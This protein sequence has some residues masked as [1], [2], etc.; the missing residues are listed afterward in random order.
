[1][2][3]NPFMPFYVGDWRSDPEV[4][5]L[6]PAERGV[7]RELIDL[8]WVEKPPGTIPL[9][10]KNVVHL[11][12][13]MG[14]FTRQFNVAWEKVVKF[15]PEDPNNP[16]RRHN[17][18]IVRVLEDLERRRLRGVAGGKAR[19]AQRDGQLDAKRPVQ[20]NAPRDPDLDLEV[21]KKNPP[22]PQGVYSPEFEAFWKAYRTACFHDAPGSKENASKKWVSL[23]PDVD[24]R[25]KIMAG[26]ER[27]KSARAV[28]RGKGDFF[29]Q[30]PHAERFL[31]NRRFEDE[32]KASPIPDSPEY[33]EAVERYRQDKETLGGIDA[34][35]AL[36]A[37]HP[38]IATAVLKEV[39]LGR[40]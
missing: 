11:I 29:Q 32:F 22:T 1:M 34:V 6:S 15:W 38:D 37:N 35:E 24:L 26:V 40:T 19:Q 13:G 4:M 5:R 18:K 21:I 8:S 31:G 3:K 7:Y 27:W 30:F 20:R 28:A 36:K 9:L 33:R 17:P 25:K 12:P 14:R 39:N 2:P 16:G 23:K 10:A